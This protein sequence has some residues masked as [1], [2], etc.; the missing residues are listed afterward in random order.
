MLFR[1]PVRCKPEM[2]WKRTKGERRGVPPFTVGWARR[3]RFTLRSSCKFNEQTSRTDSSHLPAFLS[4]IP[5]GQSWVIE[6]WPRFLLFAALGR[7]LGPPLVPSH[8]S[9]KENIA[10]FSGFYQTFFYY[11]LPPFLARQCP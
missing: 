8:S 4:W 10:I 11:I 5:V 1:C 6:T 2:R 9:S 7:R 3:I